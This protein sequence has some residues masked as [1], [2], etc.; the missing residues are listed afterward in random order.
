MAGR[1][2]EDEAIR[3]FWID[4]TMNA[5]SHHQ[6]GDDLGWDAEQLAAARETLIELFEPGDTIESTS[7]YKIIVRKRLGDRVEIRRFDN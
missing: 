6:I 1:P 2:A 4:G 7:N 5:A 3:I